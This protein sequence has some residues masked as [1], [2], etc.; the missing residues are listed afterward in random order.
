MGPFRTPKGTVAK[1]RHCHVGSGCRKPHET[2]GI[3]AKTPRGRL[4]AF[5]VNLSVGDISLT[6]V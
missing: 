2:L 6:L 3:N 1:Q 4:S 5:R